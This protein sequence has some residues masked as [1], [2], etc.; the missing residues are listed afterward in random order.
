M[1]LFYVMITTAKLKFMI[2]R[3]FCAMKRMMMIKCILHILKETEMRPKIITIQI[4]AE[5]TGSKEHMGL[6]D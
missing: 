4:L 3:T 2:K 5:D 1:S 6:E